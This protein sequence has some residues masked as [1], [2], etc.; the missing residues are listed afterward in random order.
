MIHRMIL[1]VYILDLCVSQLF[2]AIGT[3]Y[4]EHKLRNRTMGVG[5]YGKKRRD[6]WLESHKLQFENNIYSG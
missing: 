6:S 5:T 1:T 4:I 2:I 3:G